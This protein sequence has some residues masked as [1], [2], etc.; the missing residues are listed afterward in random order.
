MSPELVFRFNPI[1]PMRKLLIGSLVLA[2]PLAAQ[3]PAIRLIAA[4]DAQSKPI[5]GA[6]PAV[7]QLPGGGLLVNDV[8]KRQL[9]LLDQALTS[10]TIVADSEAGR[11][12]SY[13]T[14]PGG[15]ISYLGDSSLFVDPAGLSM[16]V[17]DPAGKIAR[18]ASV[19]RSQDAGMIASA[20]NI[21]GLDSKGRL[22]YRGGVTFVRNTATRSGPP[23]PGGA[24]FSLPEPPDSAAIVR[25]DMTSRK[26]DTVAYYKIP[27]TKLKVEQ[28]ER[29]ISATSEINPMPLVDEWAVLADGSVAIVRGQD[30]HVDIISADGNV[31]SGTKI[32]F[33]WQRLT[34]E[35]KAAVIDS[36]KKAFEAA[37]AAT[38]SGAASQMGAVA[39]AASAAP[40][41]V[42][43]MSTGGGDGG[44]G[45][46]QRVM[47]GGG[48]GMGSMT[49]IS[50][51][52]LPD[53]RPAFG[54]GAVRADAD[55]NAWIRTS[56]KGAT[57]GQVYDVVNSH[58]QLVERI[59]I[60]AGRSIVGF[61]KGG[62]VYMLARDSA[63][64]WIERT[65]R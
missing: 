7:R 20:A 41:M 56:A 9:T 13:G 1:A 4:P 34:D 8:Q 61:G 47:A 17:I 43:N 30:Y 19:P 22:V 36:A 46:A 49:F 14:R 21:P 54:T 62:I 10:A 18:V 59:Q 15:I 3:A 25:V 12:N 29:G 45:L 28:T 16:F 35:D 64:N 57:P 40:R 53:Y 2:S 51:S 38:A 58:G 65:H 39:A 27:K 37:S 31:S 50:P 52:E 6:V 48:P 63:G 60:P 44:G 42:I 33:D 55:G 23:A 32:P 24:G 5:F 26:V 11:P